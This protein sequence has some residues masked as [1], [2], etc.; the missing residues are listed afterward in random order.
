MFDTDM[1]STATTRMWLK[2][3]RLLDRSIAD[4]V[5]AG[6]VATAVK[7][8]RAAEACYWQATGEGD[9]SNLKDVIE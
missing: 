3:A 8:A 4:Y 1:A 7:T 6:H 5:I 2:L 9:C